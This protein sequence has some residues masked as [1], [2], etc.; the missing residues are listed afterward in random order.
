MLNL[1]TSASRYCR[2]FNGP[3]PS[4]AGICVVRVYIA[5]CLLAIAFYF[6]VGPCLIYVA[7]VCIYI[8]I[9]YIFYVL[10]LFII[11]S[12]LND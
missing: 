2:A 8:Y 11:L 1:Y 7:R 12:C 9:V 10:Y 6:L 5:N 3:C 4:W